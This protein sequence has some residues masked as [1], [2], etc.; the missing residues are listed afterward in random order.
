MVLRVAGPSIDPAE[1]EEEVA[2]SSLPEAVKAEIEKKAGKGKILVIES[3]TKNISPD[4]H[5]SGV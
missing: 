3:I 4:P 1:V 2:L 5:S